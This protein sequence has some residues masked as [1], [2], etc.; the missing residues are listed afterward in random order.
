LATVDRSTFKGKR[1]YAILRL[2]WDNALRRGELVAAN[3]G[4]FRDGQLWIV[5]KGKLQKCSIDLAPATV[6]AL[7][8]WLTVRDGAGDEPLF[9]A[10]DTNTFG[11]RLSGR[12][13]ARLVAAASLSDG[14]DGEVNP[15]VGKRMSPHKVRH[16]SITTFLDAS[17]GDVRTAQRLSRHSRLDTLMIYDDNRQGLQGKASIVLADLV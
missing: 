1:D 16:S 11:K 3:V 5:G 7:R 6:M 17:N 10:V 8:E 9:I 4:D 15:L 13:V 2:L 14:G 12:S